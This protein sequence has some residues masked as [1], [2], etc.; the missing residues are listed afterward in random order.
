MIR[1]H[2]GA[3][4]LSITKL[5]KPCGISRKTGSKVTERYLRVGS[6]G[7]DPRILSV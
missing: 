1:Y 3:K 5:C 7:F 4:R 2:T 6:R